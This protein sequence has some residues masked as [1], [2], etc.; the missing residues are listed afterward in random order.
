MARPKPPRLFRYLSPAFFWRR[1]GDAYQMKDLWELAKDFNFLTAAAGFVTASL[2]WLWRF[3]GENP[4]AV[5]VTLFVVAV[6]LT[7]LV[8]GFLIHCRQM[9]K[10]MVGPSTEAI[11]ASVVPTEPPEQPRLQLV[12]RTGKHPIGDEPYKIRANVKSGD[13]GAAGVRV[14]VDWM[15]PLEKRK[16]LSTTASQVTGVRLLA[17]E[18]LNAKEAAGFDVATFDPADPERLT[19]HTTDGDRRVRAG[20]PL[21]VKLVASGEN[22]VAFEKEYVVTATRRY[23]SIRFYGE[24]AD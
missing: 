10:V 3:L 9:R 5:N 13:V 17:P 18:T 21:A 1:V 22:A 2:A 24:P 11:A 14:N 4:P 15:E 16:K 6:S 12:I 8:V 23:V 19:L 7:A 20:H